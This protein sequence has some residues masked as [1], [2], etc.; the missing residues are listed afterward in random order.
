MAEP[1]ARTRTA[2]TGST[3]AP[4]FWFRAATALARRPAL[5]WTA[6]RLLLRI[7][8]PRWWRRP[9]FVPV[10]D[11]AYL[12]FRLETAYGPRGV[13]QVEDLLAYLSWCREQG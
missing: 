7:A 9:P 2:P 10:P 5:W 8:R 11:P 13:V 1:R 3:L 12:R 6:I 4:R